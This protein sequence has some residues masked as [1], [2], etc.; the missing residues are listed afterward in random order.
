M[1]AETNLPIVAI[2]ANA[3]AGDRERCLEAGMD[4]YISKPIDVDELVAVLR[5]T[6]PG[7]GASDD[8]QPEGLDTDT[9]LRRVQGNTA[10]AAR[11]ARTFR[12]E[13]PGHVTRLRDAL[14]RC[15]PEA[16]YEAAHAFKGA[17]GALG[18]TALCQA[19]QRL[20]E[21]GR[22]GNLDD[23]MAHVLA[24]LARVAPAL[25]RLAGS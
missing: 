7:A 3:L 11:L 21:L 16:V 6:V 24:T 25:D 5:D 17:A 23:A 12:Q 22:A 4:A 15:D 2:T 14:A 20:E 9:I 8:A 19:A 18:A 10:L 1:A 13:A